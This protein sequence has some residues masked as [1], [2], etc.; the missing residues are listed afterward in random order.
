MKSD[1]L[2]LVDNNMNGTEP[3]EITHPLLNAYVAGKDD[4]IVTYKIEQDPNIQVIENL[5]FYQ[6]WGNNQSF[7]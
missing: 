3:Q 5:L 1:T 2:L 4:A 7:R 6:K